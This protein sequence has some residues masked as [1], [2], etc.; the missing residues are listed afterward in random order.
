MAKAVWSQADSEANAQPRGSVLHHDS[1]NHLLHGMC[2]T[3]WN[4]ALRHGQ[5]LSVAPLQAP[6]LI[7]SL[8]TYL[9][10]VTLDDGEQVVN[11]G[12]DD[13]IVYGLDGSVYRHLSAV[14]FNR[15]AYRLPTTRPKK[16]G[17]LLFA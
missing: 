12:D 15:F 3:H 13:V 14:K 11:N 17:S 10:V 5:K 6:R 9:T 1:G 16:K 8:D 2:E 4:Q 7:K